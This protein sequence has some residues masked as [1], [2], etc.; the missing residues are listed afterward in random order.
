MCYPRLGC[1]GTAVAGG[2]MVGWCSGY[3][4]RGRG[5]ILLAPPAGQG[6]EKAHEG[7]HGIKQEVILPGSRTGF[8]QETVL[9]Q[10]HALTEDLCGY[11]P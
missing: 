6:G 11:L 3:L 10:S 4:R 8:G 9:H 5:L 1:E 7:Q 2:S